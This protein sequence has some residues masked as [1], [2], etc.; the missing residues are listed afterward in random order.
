M[1][2]ATEGECVQTL[3]SYAVQNGAIRDVRVCGSSKC[4]KPPVAAPAAHKPPPRK[5]GGRRRL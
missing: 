3:T 2:F 5:T 4:N 1:E